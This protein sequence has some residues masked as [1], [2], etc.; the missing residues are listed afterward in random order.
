MA[1]P[2]PL[3]SLQPFQLLTGLKRD[4]SKPTAPLATIYKKMSILF[5]E[6]SRLYLRHFQESDVNDLFRTEGNPDVM[7][8]IRKPV[9]EPSQSLA[10]IR[11]E[12]VYAAEN[13]GL[14]LFACFEKATD[15]Y[16]GLVKIKHIDNTDAIEVGYAFLPEAWGKGYATEITQKAIEYLNQ[17]FKE[18]EIVAFIQADNLNSR[19]VLEKSGM[20]EVENIYKGHENALVFE[21]ELL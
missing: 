10:R 4:F 16:L 15:T 5:L 21:L 19:R 8:F 12:T 1:S 11:Q 3:V 20:T 7:A 18:R 9:A 17:N 14:G 6:S 13:E 2:M